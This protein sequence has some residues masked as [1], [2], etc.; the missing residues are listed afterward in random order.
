V[1]SEHCRLYTGWHRTYH[2]TIF[3]AKLVRQQTHVCHYLLQ[4]WQLHCHSQHNSHKTLR[5]DYK[6]FLHS[7]PTILTA[8]HCRW[9]ANLLHICH[10]FQTRNKHQTHNTAS[11]TQCLDDT[12]GPPVFQL[13]THPTI[14]WTS[15]T[16]VSF[17][18]FMST[19]DVAV[20][21]N[22]HS[23]S[24]KYICHATKKSGEVHTQNIPFVHQLSTEK[25]RPL[26]FSTDLNGSATT[27]IPTRFI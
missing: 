5:P 4:S 6:Q 22:G 17:M 11:Y 15:G 27:T 19:V 8:A 9:K 26:S 25:Y 7:P 24:M 18:A 3:S 1:T 10:P 14:F 2:H 21:Q 13:V 16:T 20:F 12:H 23:L